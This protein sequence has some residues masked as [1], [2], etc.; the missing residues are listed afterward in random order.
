MDVNATSKL[1]A[2]EF[3]HRTDELTGIYSP[4]TPEVFET[5]SPTALAALDEVENPDHIP[6]QSFNS[7]MEASN[8]QVHDHDI[9]EEAD[10]IKEIDEGLLMELDAVGDF[11]VEEF[12]SNLHKIEN[13]VSAEQMNSEMPSVEARSTEEIDSN[14]ERT[15]PLAVKA[16]VEIREVE[17]PQESQIKEEIIESGMPEFEARSIDDMDRAFR[18]MSEEE[19]KMPFVIESVHSKMVP[20][21]TR[22]ECSEYKISHKDSSLAETEME[23]PVVEAT[24]IEDLDLA[25][26]QLNSSSSSLVD[27]HSSMGSTDPVESDSD[28][29]VERQNKQ[30]SHNETLDVLESDNAA[31]TT[32]ELHFTEPRSLEDTGVTLKSDF[33]DASGKKESIE[34]GSSEEIETS[35]KKHGIPETSTNG[36]EQPDHG[37][38]KSDELGSSIS[39][40]KGKK[41]KSGK[42]SCSS[43]SSSSSSSDSE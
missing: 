26:K 11:G 32:S 29:H 30:N 15:E 38:Q 8:S 2:S 23:L 42:S 16:E 31:E 14:F 6:V 3:Q 40:G 34:V 41:K 1:D 37:V 36:I 5:K 22:A 20:E 24:S 17:I 39:D 7:E 35:T 25:F 12:G 21:E 4:L 33:E 43:S 18:R 28:L 27:V 9:I 19:I 10:E 13:R